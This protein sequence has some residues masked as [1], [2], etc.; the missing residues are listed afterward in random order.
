MISLQQGSADDNTPRKIAARKYKEM[1]MSER[2]NNLREKITLIQA[3][4]NTHDWRRGTITSSTISAKV[5]QIFFI[6][7]LENGKIEVFSECMLCSAQLR[8]RTKRTEVTDVWLV[9]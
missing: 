1:R 8:H 9:E 7:S 5:C 4:I 6:F 3:L 2:R